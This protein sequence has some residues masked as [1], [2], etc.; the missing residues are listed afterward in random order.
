MPPGGWARPVGGPPPIAKPYAGWW[1]RVGA[2][3]FDL[4]VISVPALVLAIVVFGSAGAAF[5]AGDEFGFV[6]LMVGVFAY[7]GMLFAAGM[8][9]APL[10]IRRDDERTGQARG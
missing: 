7:V 5:G 1:S 4:L 3:L 9:Y 8:P 2:A 6:A 10:A